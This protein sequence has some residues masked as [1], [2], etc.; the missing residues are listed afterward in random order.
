M[1][2]IIKLKQKVYENSNNGNVQRCRH[3][4]SCESINVYNPVASR[5]MRVL[6]KMQDASECQKGV[7]TKNC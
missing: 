3:Y 6:V 1:Y 7:T 4:S 2:F 5:K